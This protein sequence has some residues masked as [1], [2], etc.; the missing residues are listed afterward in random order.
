MQVPP[1]LKNI[2]MKLFMWKMYIHVYLQSIS[3]K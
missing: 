1:V 2:V 3:V